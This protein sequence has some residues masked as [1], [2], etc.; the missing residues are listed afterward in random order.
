[1]HDRRLHQVDVHGHQD[2]RLTRALPL[3]LVY[4][5]LEQRVALYL[6]RRL[7]ACLA[8]KGGKL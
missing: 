7:Q 1:M 5:S 4:R 3:T 6:R 8:K 2:Q